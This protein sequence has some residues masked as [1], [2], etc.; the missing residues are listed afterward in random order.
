MIHSTAIIGEKVK[1]E[2]GVEIGPYS[3]I[4]GNVTIGKKPTINASVSIVGNTTRGVNDII[5]SFCSLGSVPQDL[6]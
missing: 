3:F 1:L 2:S 6:K 4:E 5:V